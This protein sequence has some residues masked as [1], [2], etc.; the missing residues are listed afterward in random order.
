VA[1]C[2]KKESNEDTGVFSNPL[3]LKH[4]LEGLQYALGD[5]DVE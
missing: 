3:V 4:W 5:I 1:S 2:G